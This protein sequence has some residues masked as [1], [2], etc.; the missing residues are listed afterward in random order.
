MASSKRVSKSSSRKTREAWLKHE[1]D[2]RNAQI[3]AEI[4]LLA[5]EDRLIRKGA[6]MCGGALGAILVW[7]E[8]FFLWA[9]HG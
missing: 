6:A 7:L 1:Q 4:A 9:I 3:D 5:E 8:L 2:L